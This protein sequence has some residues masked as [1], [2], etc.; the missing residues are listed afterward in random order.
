LA[1]WVAKSFACGERIR[2]VARFLRK[3]SHAQGGLWNFSCLIPGKNE[4]RSER[5]DQDQYDRGEGSSKR[6]FHAVVFRKITPQVP[7]KNVAKSRT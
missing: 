4:A 6:A 1:K 3:G 5:D 7:S 2:N